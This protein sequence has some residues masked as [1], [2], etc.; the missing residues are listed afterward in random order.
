MVTP[1]LFTLSRIALDLDITS[2]LLADLTLVSL[3]TPRRMSSGAQFSNL[4][5]SRMTDVGV[6]SATVSK[7]NVLG[8]SKLQNIAQ[9]S[10]SFDS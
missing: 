2:N 3:W 6:A 8:L 4:E 10:Q 9:R 1:L 7:L 5:R